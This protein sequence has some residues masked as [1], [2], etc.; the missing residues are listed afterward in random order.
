[1]TMFKK[2]SMLFLTLIFITTLPTSVMATP[3]ELTATA[4]T[5]FNQMISSN[6]SASATTMNSRYANVLLLQHQ[7]QEWDKKIKDLHY[8]NEET[9]ILLKKQ[10]QLI[11]SSKINTLQ[12]QV[13]QARDRYNPLFS[14]YESLNRQKSVAKKLKNKD[15]YNILLSQSET[16]KIAVQL[17]RADIRN[18]ENLLS[19]AKSNTATLKKK[20]RGMLE[21]IAPLKVQIKVAKNDTSMSQKR[22]TAE[23]SIL[24]QYIKS[25]SVNSTLK[26]LEGLITHIQKV[27]EHKQKILSLEQMISEV[28]RK[29][30]LQTPS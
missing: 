23:T 28:I 10:I 2:L 4:K 7:D 12:T 16:M 20:L 29:T 5:Q 30:K 11:D 1:M 18:K 9:L 3:F 17:A 22:F 27:I 14:M 19:T 24:K 26:S 15:F 8:T 6:N 13:T 21:D 25:G